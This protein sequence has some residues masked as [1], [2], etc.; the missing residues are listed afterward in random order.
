VELLANGYREAKCRGSWKIFDITATSIFS[1]TG[2]Q[3]F[4]SAKPKPAQYLS[5]NVFSTHSMQTEK[6]TYAAVNHY[7]LLAQ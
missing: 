4:K 1:L 3:A 7:P 6:Y 2:P 5:F